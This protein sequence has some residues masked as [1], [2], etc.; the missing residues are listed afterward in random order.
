VAVGM[1][2]ATDGTVDVLFDCGVGGSTRC[3]VWFEELLL[4]SS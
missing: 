3:S 1:A 4:A 2:V